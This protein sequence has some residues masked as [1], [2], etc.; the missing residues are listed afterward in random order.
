M[1]RT[2]LNYIRLLRASPNLTLNVSRPMFPSNTSLSNLFQC[3]ITFIVKTFSLTPN[4]NQPSCLHW[5]G[6][7]SYAGCLLTYPLSLV[8]HHLLPTSC[9]AFG[10]A[11]A[12]KE[13]FFFF[14]FKEQ[15]F[16]LIARKRERTAAAQAS[17][18]SA[19]ST[20]LLQ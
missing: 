8:R 13:H 14:S 2:S 19:S 18:E 11:G 10:K 7:G 3:F 5:E 15:S 6:S 4:L 20:C 16:L 1:S 9:T 17:P 12:S